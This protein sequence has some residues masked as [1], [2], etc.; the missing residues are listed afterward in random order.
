[1][2]KPQFKYILCEKCSLDRRHELVEDEYRC[3]SCIQRYTEETLEELESQMNDPQVYL[4]ANTADLQIQEFLSSLGSSWE[5]DSDNPAEVLIETAGRSCYMSFPKKE[6]GY[7]NP[8]VKGHRR[9]QSDYMKNILKEG[10]GSILEHS[11]ASF[12]FLG[13][14]RVFTHELVRNRVGTA[15]SQESMRYVLIEDRECWVPPSLQDIP[16]AEDILRENMANAIDMYQSLLYFAAKK[17]GLKDFNDKSQ[18]HT[19]P[20]LFELKK[21]YTSAARRVI[22]IGVGTSMVWTANFRTL[23]HVIEQRTA[24]FAEEEIALVFSRVAEICIENWPHIFGDLKPSSSPLW[25]GGYEYRSE[26][27]TRKV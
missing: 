5:S 13:V 26:L 16:E 17:H 15:I 9:A 8:N 23:R 18:G 22:P 2:V 19:T 20:E 14:S 27:G 10:D 11:S 1:M 25:H 24:Q 21:K 7:V 4:I 6:G 12:A 3:L